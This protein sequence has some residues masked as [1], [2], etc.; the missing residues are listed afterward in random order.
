L[1]TARPSKDPELLGHQIATRRWWDTRRSDYDVFTSQAVRDEAGKGNPVMAAARL[2][3]LA[4]FPILPV[5]P[6]TRKVEAAFMALGVLPTSAA[7][8]ALHLALA[9]VHGMNF[10]LTWN[11]KHINNGELDVRYRRVCAAFGLSLPVIATPEEL[12][13][14]MP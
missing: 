3:V 8:D 12:M 7:M 11:C 1:L 9:V 4:P 13:H 14:S 2:S 5:T 6:E 10:L